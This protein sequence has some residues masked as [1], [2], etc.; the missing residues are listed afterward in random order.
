MP[1]RHHDQALGRIRGHRQGE[2]ANYRGMHN[3]LHHGD[4]MS[5]GDRVEFP[6][7][8]RQMLISRKRGSG[9][10]GP[11]SELSCPDVRRRRTL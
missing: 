3:H 7:A 5:G 10:E 1:R 2:G 9:C 8:E 6:L 4:P 11:A